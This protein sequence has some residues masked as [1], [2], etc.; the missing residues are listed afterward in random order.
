MP[1]TENA[2]LSVTFNRCAKVTLFVNEPISI[3]NIS[4]NFTFASL[5]T[6]L[7]SPTA[8]APLISSNSIIVGLGP[9]SGILVSYIYQPCSTVAVANILTSPFPASESLKSQEIGFCAFR[10]TDT[11]N[12]KIPMPNCL[13]AIFFITVL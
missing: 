9:P 4:S 6:D 13:R 3:W 1:I 8:T 2:D 7:K 5:S 12:N 11:R 10:V